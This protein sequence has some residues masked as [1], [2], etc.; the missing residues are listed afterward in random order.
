MASNS[1]S[2][3]VLAAGKGTRM[4][5]DRPKV[6]HEIGARSLLHHV[7]NAATALHAQEVVVVVGPGMESVASAA[8]AAI[9]GVKIAVQQQ[10]RGTGDAVRAA[11]PMVA[12]GD[13]V[14][15]FG[16]TPLVGI[17]PIAPMLAARKAGASIV[18]LGFR[19][20]D[21]ARY[22]RLVTRP[23][24]MEV[25]RIVEYADASAAELKID[26]CNSGIFVIDGT[27]AARLIGA[28][29]S[30]NAKHE[31]YL[32]D[33]VAIGAAQGLKTCAVEA[34]DPDDVLGVNSR[35]E[36][37]QAEAIF[38]DRA[39]RAAM[40]AGATL[41]DP[42]TVYFATD[43]K[44]GMD[45]IIGPNVVFG[46]GVTIDDNVRIEAFS[47]IEG[48]HVKRGARV[49]PFARL[50][51]GADIGENAH[52]GNYVEIKKAVIEEGA[53]VN[54]LTYIG[55]ARVGAATN[56]GAGTITCNYDG[57]DK[58][59]TD[60]GAGAFIGS[61]TA[62]IAPVKVGD[63]AYVGSGSVIARDVPPDALALTR[64]ELV[65]KPGWAAKF[66]ARRRRPT[67]AKSDQG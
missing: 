63:G 36:L 1:P 17:K 55:D 40:D 44:L 14:V 56:V 66:R 41:I 33:I 54:H 62:L 19:P 51:P 50:R 67:K 23:G 8:K 16:D 21:P 37:A 13:L 18:V 58:H 64:A 60:I 12:G 29:K 10:A 39:R 7:L 59:F 24:T 47:H 61:N 49:G 52:I 43:T 4:R 20:Q 6:L 22:G 3:V 57:H 27:V 25:E 28:I 65:E 26:L 38:Q 2:V 46:P 34:G 30:N 35:A 11:L 5:S 15:L 9:P 53:K 48:A 32:T 31:F 42:K 45:V